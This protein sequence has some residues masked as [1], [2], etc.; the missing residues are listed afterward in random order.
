VPLRRS[1]CMRRT[2]DKQ[3]LGSAKYNCRKSCRIWS[4]NW[5][6][7]IVSSM[8]MSSIRETELA[9]G[10]LTS[11]ADGAG[12]RGADGTD[13]AAGSTLLFFCATGSA[14]AASA[15]PCASSAQPL[16]I[17]E[18]Y[19][20]S[21]FVCLFVCV[22]VCLCLFVCLFDCLFVWWVGRL[23]DY[24]NQFHLGPS[25]RGRRRRWAPPPTR[26]PSASPS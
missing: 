17:V 26:E 6:L 22:F 11:S 16:Q 12:S 25:S 10:S 13:G 7:R 8:I 1:R 23:R 19:T 2:M 4:S 14:T 15:S 20:C 9:A 3:A 5:M 24:A 21:L 18:S